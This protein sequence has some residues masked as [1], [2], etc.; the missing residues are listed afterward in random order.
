MVRAAD[1]GG[2]RRSS[3]RLLYHIPQVTGVPLSRGAGGAARRGI[4]GVVAGVKDS[5]GDWANTLALLAARPA[6]RDPRRP[7]AASA[8][9]ACARAAPGRSAASPTC[10][11]SS[12][13]RC[14]PAE[15]SDADEARIATFIEIACPPAVPRPRS[16]RIVAATTRDPGWLAVRPP[17]VAL[18]TARARRCSRRWRRACRRRRIAA[19]RLGRKAHRAIRHACSMIPGPPAVASSRDDGPRTP[20]RD[21]NRQTSTRR[22]PWQIAIDSEAGRT[23]PPPVAGRARRSRAGRP[24]RRR[25]VRC[26]GAG[27][28][29]LEALQG[30][31]DRGVPGQ[32]PARRSPHQVPQG[33]R[34]PD[35]HHGRLRDD[36]RAAAAAEG[37]HRVQF[38]QHE[39]RRDRASRTTCRSGCSARTSGS[40]TSARSSP[41]SR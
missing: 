8:A 28:V 37:G 38:G 30:R 16:R 13:R 40:R 7:R 5:A 32:E 1:R 23:T 35:R 15:V 39:L 11:R 27:H 26:A 4:S 29:R 24:S 3:A 25:A 34:G 18:A 6:A 19:V 9:P 33:I 17:Q 41:T 21:T 14:F 12:S 36:P 20:I 2:R 31:E 10:I 22:T